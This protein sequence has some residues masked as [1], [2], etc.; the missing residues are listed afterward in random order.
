M[1]PNMAALF[2]GWSQSPRLPEEECVF[3][4]KG[5]LPNSACVAEPHRGHHGVAVSERRE[6]SRHATSGPPA[7]LLWASPIPRAPP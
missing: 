3:R 4:N 6:H 5:H 7:A 1:H 2:W